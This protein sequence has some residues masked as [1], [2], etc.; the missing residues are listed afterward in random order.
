MLLKILE[1][2]QIGIPVSPE[3]LDQLETPTINEENIPSIFI[4]KQYPIVECYNYLDSDDILDFD[5]DKSLI[6]PNMLEISSQSKLF[7]QPEDEELFSYI[8]NNVFESNINN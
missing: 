6:D 4:P 3:L 7:T 8:F 2:E 1:K 5:P